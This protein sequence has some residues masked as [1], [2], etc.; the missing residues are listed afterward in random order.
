M[1]NSWAFSWQLVR[2]GIRSLV[3]PPAIHFIDNHTGQL[4]NTVIRF[5][6]AWRRTKQGHQLHKEAPLIH[7]WEAATQLGIKRID[8][9]FMSHLQT[10]IGGFMLAISWQ[11][12]FHQ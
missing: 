7:Q 9:K 2:L 4:L 6:V 11:S 5:V 1:R 10:I 3:I 8:R 12:F